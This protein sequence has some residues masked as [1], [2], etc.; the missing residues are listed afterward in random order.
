MRLMRL[1]DRVRTPPGNQP[2]RSI[3]ESARKL[4]TGASV[5]ALVIVGLVVVL[6]SPLI[7]R[8]LAAADL[9]WARLS[10]VGQT[11][12]AASA[13]L[14]ML[15]LGAVAASLFVQ[16]RQ[17]RT[18][19][20]Q[21]VRQLHFE[22]TRI[23]LDNPPLY[24]PCWGPLNVSTM[25]DKQRMIYTNQIFNYLRTGYEIGAFT[26]RSFRGGL[27]N[28]FKGEVGREYWRLTRS[29]WREIA[30]S[31]RLRAFI[32]IVDEQYAKAMAAGPPV[33]LGFQGDDSRTSTNG[34]V[35]NR[36]KAGRRLQVHILVS[37]ASGTIVG[38]AASLGL[39]RRGQTLRHGRRQEKPATPQG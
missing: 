21:A 10:D 11:Y 30:D 7:L 24:Q 2:E 8:E 14:A 4:L 16:A 36:N 27:Y 13:I 19:S 25:A 39:I 9:D 23:E 1:G 12:G 33:L 3:H 5:L 31:R 28:L 17:T 38:A 29:E 34:T 22:L 35:Q 26:E 18:N 20:I 37:F 15:A 32:Q 6:L